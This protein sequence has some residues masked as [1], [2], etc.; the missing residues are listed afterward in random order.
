MA[1]TD[2]FPLLIVDL[3]KEK[4]PYFVDVSILEEEL[5]GL[6]VKQLEAKLA[7]AVELQG[8]SKG[9]LLY[10]Q[11][12]REDKRVKSY[13]PSLQISNGARWMLEYTSRSCDREE[14][15]QI[16]VRTLTGKTLDLKVTSYSTIENIKWKIYK[17]EGI[18]PEE[19]RL[20]FGQRELKDAR[21]I[22]DYN[23]QNEDMLL[24]VL[25]M[26]GGGGLFADIE[27]SSQVQQVNIV[28][29][30]PEWRVISEGLNIEGKC[31][32]RN[33]GAFQKLV[34]IKNKMEQF[35][36]LID[37]M[38]CPMCNAQV[39]PITCGFYRCQWRFEGVKSQ[40]MKEVRSPWYIAEGEKYHRFNS[41][42]SK[43][44]E[45]ASLS[46]IPMRIDRNACDYC[47][48]GFD[49]G[50]KQTLRCNHE[51]HSKCLEAWT[52]HC[53]R[54]KKPVKCPKCHTVIKGR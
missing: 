2:S 42:E 49:S 11:R 51:V 18:L 24:L 3:L 27:D 35:N 54:N 8:L 41:E 7:Q 47:H 19:Q 1:M 33:C 4:E 28:A 30:G 16:Y 25:R 21:T 52:I 17:M 26:R 34:I 32:N 44:I 31:L 29:E 43:L 6:T 20:R 14:A 46:I 23:I 37:S 38:S 9:L 12:L 22:A 50:H 40:S 5:E 15:R 39:T 45:W 13:I 48:K 36:L 53:L 10:G